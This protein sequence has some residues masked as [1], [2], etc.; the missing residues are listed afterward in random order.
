[1]E[2]TK[3]IQELKDAVGSFNYPFVWTNDSYHILIGKYLVWVFVNDITLDFDVTVDIW[4]D[5]NFDQNIEWESYS[6]AQDALK[7]FYE[8]VGEYL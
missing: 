7:R 2:M 3:K 4:R 1:M 8:F 5:G 6:D